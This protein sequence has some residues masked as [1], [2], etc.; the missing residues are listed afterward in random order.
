MWAFSA[1]AGKL[2]VLAGET[3]AAHGLVVSSC[4]TPSSAG[5]LK[6]SRE[7]IHFTSGLRAQGWKGSKVVRKLDPENQKTPGNR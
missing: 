4:V 1:F 2:G 7:Q 5:D 6:N 3:G